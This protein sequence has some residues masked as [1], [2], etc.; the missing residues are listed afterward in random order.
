M[1]LESLKLGATPTPAEI[2]ADLRQIEADRSTF[3]Q[4]FH[5][6]DKQVLGLNTKSLAGE[7]VEAKA[8]KSA[9]E[10]RS[11]ASDQLRA[12]DEAQNRLHELLR[13]A[14]AARNA[15]RIAEL[16]ADAG[17]VNAQLDAA[18]NRLVDLAAEAVAWLMRIGF[19]PGPATEITGCRNVIAFKTLRAMLVASPG[20]LEIDGLHP[21]TL[22]QFT[23]QI[24]DTSNRRHHQFLEHK[25]DTGKGEPSLCEAAADLESQLN[26]LKAPTAV[27]RECRELLAALPAAGEPSEGDTPAD[28]A[29]EPPMT[30]AQAA[31]AAEQRDLLAAT[32]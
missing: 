5:E 32:G 16:E 23:Q 17:K 15:E 30:G 12:F 9:R 21:V 7:P 6:A 31:A 18:K 3:E 22:E 28:A 19:V 24:E 4:A 2:V 8:L 13:E 10:K 11:A 27:E 25:L 1:K 26:N 29:S 20:L 14:V